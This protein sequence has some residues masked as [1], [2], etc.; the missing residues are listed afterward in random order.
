MSVYT[1]R[2]FWAG[3]AE[4]SL[5]TAAQT[6]IAVIGT[7]TLGI[8]DVDWL[9]AL[10]VAGLATVLS[11]LTSVAQPEF[12]AGEADATPVPADYQ[13]RHRAHPDGPHGG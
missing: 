3:V 11:V 2:A 9:T 7:G 1:T 8:L 12:V 4:R 13:P 6:L 5:K 10:S